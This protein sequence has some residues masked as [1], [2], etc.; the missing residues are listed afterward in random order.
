M[1]RKQAFGL[2]LFAMGMSACSGAETDETG[3]R[4]LT[5]RDGAVLTR[6]VLPAPK[7]EISADEL[8]YFRPLPARKDA[9]PVLLFH[10]VCPS[11]CAP[12]DT[13][14]VSQLE[15][16]RILNMLRV[17]G[18]TS[19]SIAAYDAFH[20]GTSRGLPTQP[21]LLTFDDG[22]L[23]AYRGADA[24]LAAAGARA[25]QFIITEKPESGAAQFMSWA[26][27]A[28]AQAS[29]RWDIQL[30]GHHGH[31]RIPTSPAQGNA[32]LG[33]FYGNLAYSPV[34]YPEG[35]HLETLEQ[36]RARTEADVREG[37][38]LL[39]QHV[40]GYV[41][42]TFALPFGDY[43]QFRSMTNDER[44]GPAQRA[45]LDRRFRAWF[46]Q[47]SSDPDFTTRGKHEVWRYTVRFGTTAETLYAWLASHSGVGGIREAA[48]AAAAAGA[49]HD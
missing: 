5:G 37:E 6:T 9:I 7:V 46:T 40:P 25:T 35:N 13:Y 33:A 18:F 31:R 16:A 39:A 23:D 45:F 42:L 20:A 8:A 11:E 4:G 2:F 49:G 12:S 47:P 14:G 38:A 29:G 48:K 36:W 26:E 3:T 43:G 30:H 1:G 34:L 27:I 32:G 21:I 15:L 44:I 17:A 28:A 22:R 24:I 10:Q 19:I 41:P